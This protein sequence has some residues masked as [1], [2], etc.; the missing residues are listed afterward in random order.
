MIE[1]NLKP[2]NSITRSR[3]SLDIVLLA[4][5]VGADYLVENRLRTKPNN[6]LIDPAA[7]IL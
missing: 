1:L 4:L 2:T 5:I 7:N 3:Y 6:R